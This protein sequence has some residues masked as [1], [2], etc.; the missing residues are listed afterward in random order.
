M[1]WGRPPWQQ[2]PP[3]EETPPRAY[4]PQSRHPPWSRL[5]PQSRPPWEQTPPPEQTSPPG[6]R[7]SPQADTPREQSILRDTVNARAVRILM[8]CNL[9]WGS[10]LLRGVIHWFL[11]VWFKSLLCPETF[12][13]F[14]PEWRRTP[15]FVALEGLTR[16]EAVN[17]IN[18]I[19][20]SPNEANFL[21]MTT[22]CWEGNQKVLCSALKIIL[23]MRSL[24]F[25]P[26]TLLMLGCARFAE[27]LSELTKTW[28]SGATECGVWI[29]NCNVKVWKST[30]HKLHNIWRSVKFQQ[31]E[32]TPD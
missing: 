13:R 1:H 19:T 21:L 27:I 28:S 22:N 24:S 17:L 31:N 32:H 12:L 11:F 3:L 8:E 26:N 18:Q 30:E 15:Y 9:V 20:N 29:G 2:T 4:T 7:H 10:I 14:C 5:P 6:S 16:K 23:V 25:E